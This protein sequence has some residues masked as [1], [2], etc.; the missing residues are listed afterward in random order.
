MN[1]IFQ[2]KNFLYF[3]VFLVGAFTRYDV[4]IIARLPLGELLAFATL[5]LFLSGNRMHFA[6]RAL[7]VVYWVVGLWLFS[8]IISDVF[9]G[10]S[11]GRFIRGAMKPIFVGFWVLFFACVIQTNFRAIYY[12]AIGLVVASVQNYIFPQAWTVKYV[13][14]GGYEGVAFGIVPIIVS[15]GIA[16]AVILYRKNRLWAAL[17][18]FMTVV[19]HFYFGSPRST[20]AL[21]LLNVLIIIVIWLRHRTGN[22]K[23][24]LSMGQLVVLAGVMG[25]F[26]IMIYYT[27]VYAA[28]HGLMGEMQY[29]KINDQVNTVFGTSPLGLLLGGRT[30]VFAA[31]LA[32]LDNP[33]LGYGSWSGAWLG[34]YFYEAIAYVGTDP[35]TMDALNSG[36]LLPAPGHSIFFTSWMENGILSAVAFLIALYIVCR[37]LLVLLNFDS[38]FAPL[39]VFYGVNFLWGFFFSPFGVGERMAMGMFFALYITKF[40]ER[41]QLMQF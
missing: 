39:F 3:M 14:G 5:P 23:R 15:L 36:G 17:A 29:A 35:S 4:T 9:S 26:G 8:V 10:V 28:M 16:L 11:F 32:I 1:G 41:G 7:N 34:D 33:I 19:A 21:M 13:Q 2:N 18:F 24:P 22:N 38:R 6:K 25:V 27:Y 40:G 20:M 37:E 12:F 31:I 30:A